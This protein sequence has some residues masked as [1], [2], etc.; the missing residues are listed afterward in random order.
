MLR[1][2]I[3][4]NPQPAQAAP[5]GTTVSLIGIDEHTI[6]SIALL[7][8]GGF[9]VICADANPIMVDTLGDMVRSGAAGQ[10]V[11]RAHLDDD[12]LCLT[13]DPF[14]AVMESTIT[15]ICQGVSESFTGEADDYV[16]SVLGRTIGAALA[17]KADY[18][19]VVQ[20]AS[21]LPGTTRNVLISAIEAASGLEAGAGFG[22]CHL[23][24]RLAHLASDATPLFAGVTDLATADTIEDLLQRS[25]RRASTTLIEVSEM[26]SWAAC[27][28]A[29]ISGN[30]LRSEKADHQRDP[31]HL[32]AAPQDR[33]SLTA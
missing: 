24:D 3:K 5:A 8:R 13:D 20:Q 19:V 32:V 2:V 18:H 29:G 33:V 9:R 26:K 11:W 15:L 1:H 27:D 7:L 30:L 17:H 14:A 22:T 25:G 28:V 23:S 16:L 10:A 21:V 6:A 31:R 12:M 4:A